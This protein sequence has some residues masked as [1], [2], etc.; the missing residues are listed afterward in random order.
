M[1]FIITFSLAETHAII[2]DYSLLGKTIYL[3]AGHGG[4]DSG[5]ISNKIVE[6]DMN[7]VLVKTLEEKLIAKGATVY[8]T[9]EDDSDLSTSSYNRKRSDLYNRAKLIND[10]KCDMYISIHLNSTTSKTWRGLQIFYN[11]VLKEN[12]EIAKVINQTLKDNL[13]NIRDIK[14]E[15]DYYMYKYIKVPGILIEVGFISNPD[16]NYLL[17][18][19]DYRDKLTNYIAVGIEN[20]FNQNIS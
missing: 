14:L 11:N 3:D 7:L 1:F 17:R 5:A 9:R 10:S 15:N 18:Q 4:L 6:K 19:E 12:G 20:Y 2:N 8:V 13:S 16:D